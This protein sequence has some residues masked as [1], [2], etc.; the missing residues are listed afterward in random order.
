MTPQ[1]TS[2]S[3]DIASVSLAKRNC[4]FNDEEHDLELFSMYGHKKCIFDCLHQNA[5]KKCNCVPW[6]YPQFGKNASNIC[7]MNGNYCFES[8]LKNGSALKTCNCQPLCTHTNYNFYNYVEK[9]DNIRGCVGD[10]LD[11]PF[12]ILYNYLSHYGTYEGGG[13]QLPAFWKW[14]DK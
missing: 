2:A 11:S 1:K 14:L 5:V 3:L 6:N 9:L 12:D 7:G 13:Q 8:Q 10:K 4:K